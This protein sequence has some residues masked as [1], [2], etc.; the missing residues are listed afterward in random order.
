M[1]TQVLTVAG[2]VDMLAGLP[3]MMEV[4]VDAADKPMFING[5]TIHE[6]ATPVF[7]LLCNE[8]P[9]TRHEVTETYAEQLAKKKQQAMHMGYEK[10]KATRMPP[11]VE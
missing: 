4:V 10:D 11:I 2:L 1:S 9:I 7:V 3:P 8:V 6:G 5:N